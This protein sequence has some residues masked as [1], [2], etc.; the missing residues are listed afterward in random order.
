MI[1]LGGQR[2]GRLI[3]VSLDQARMKPGYV[4]WRC[5]CDCGN[6]KSVRSS[7]LLSGDVIS[8][9]CARAEIVAA[10]NRMLV[11]HGL[12]ATKAYEVWRHMVSRCCDPT[13]KG[14]KDYGGR[15]I[16][17]CDRWHD[18]A[19][20]VEDMGQPPKGAMIERKNNSLGYSKDNCCWAD[21]VTQNNNSR[22]NVLITY[23][24]ETLSRSQWEQK[25]GM[26]PALL[27]GRLRRGWSIE[28]AIETPIDGAD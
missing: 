13:D 16:T 11:K 25:L 10:R 6:D 5:K 7:G 14:Y 3:V 28:R 19:F 21:R 1:D 18:V 22:K 4:Y 15:G 27:R 8:C 9:G 23:R 2:F 20:F 24:G 12:S 17:V 26:K